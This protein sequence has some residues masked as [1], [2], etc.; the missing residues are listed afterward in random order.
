M[1]ERNGWIKFQR[2]MIADPT[3]N[4]DPEY[5]ALWVHLL[6]NAAF[7]PT[8]A[9]L[10]GKRIM[11]QPGQIATGRR[12]LSVNSR[13]SESKVQRILNAFENAQLIEQ[14]KTNKNR[15]ISIL[16]WPEQTVSEQQIEQQL[17]NNRTTTEQQLNT[18]EEYKNIRT[19][20]EGK[21]ADKPPRSKFVPPSVDEVRQYCRE[22]RNAVD[23]E[24]FV[25]FYAAKG[26]KIGKETMKDWKAAVRTWERRESKTV[27]EEKH[28]TIV[29]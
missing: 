26:W 21:E 20:E 12:Q 23:P 1:G 17:N 8:P 14:Q 13:I 4:K 18:L 11:L 16:S 6:C 24:T 19:E 22:R 15:L 28:E 10:G 29:C 2:S 25:D 9:L 7:E 3:I 5:L 27:T